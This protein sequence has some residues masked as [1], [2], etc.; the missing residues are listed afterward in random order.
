M[1]KSLSG[2]GNGLILDHRGPPGY[3]I[4]LLSLG[5]ASLLSTTATTVHF[6]PEPDMANP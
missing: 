5:S 2:A 1:K 3:D 4:T 6:T